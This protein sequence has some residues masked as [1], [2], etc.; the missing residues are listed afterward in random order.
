MARL[1]SNE[2]FPLKV[3]KRLRELGHDVLTSQEAKQANQSVPDEDVLA[4]ATKQNRILLT[5]NRRHF[6]ALHKKTRG[7]P[8][9]VICTQDLDYSGQAERVHQTLINQNDFANL[10]LRV[11]R[12]NKSK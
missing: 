12:P 7:H 4:F 2:N 11:N 8:G 9:I 1:Y 3:V 6:I 10:L 5:I